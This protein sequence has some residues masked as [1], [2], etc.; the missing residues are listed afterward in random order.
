MSLEKGAWGTATGVGRGAEIDGRGA[1]TARRQADGGAEPGS[2][3]HLRLLPR[4]PDLSPSQLRTRCPANTAG[5]RLVFYL[6][7]QRNTKTDFSIK[8]LHLT[9][10]ECSC[11]LG[12][13]EFR[14]SQSEAHS[15]S[16]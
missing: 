14:T 4:S 11:T 16:P 6:I 10:F 7:I 5:F 8:T 3:F 13:P 2:S 1:G 12:R 15:A 9:V